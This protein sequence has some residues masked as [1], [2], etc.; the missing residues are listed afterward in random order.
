V[1]PFRLGR[2]Q[3]DAGLLELV[4]DLRAVVGDPAIR[5]SDS[6]ITTSNLRSDR[7]ASASSSSIPPSR[8]MGRSNCR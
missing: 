3:Q 8:G 6:Q 7:L 5:S 2:Q 4:L 1:R